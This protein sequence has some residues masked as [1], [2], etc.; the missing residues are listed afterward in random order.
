MTGCTLSSPPKEI[1]IRV[2]H[3]PTDLYYKYRDVYPIGCD[4]QVDVNSDD[5]DE[6]N[7]K[8]GHA[9]ILFN[10]NTAALD[11]SDDGDE[12]DLV[13]FA[14]PHH[15]QIL[16][17]HTKINNDFQLQIG[18]VGN[19][20]GVMGNSWKMEETLSSLYWWRIGEVFTANQTDQILFQLQ[21]DMPNSPIMNV[22]DPYGFGKEIARLGRLALI[23]DEF[24][25]VNSS[26]IIR[27]YMKIS[28]E[29][30][31][32]IENEDGV[33]NSDPLKYEGTYG[34]VC[35]TNGL[36]TPGEPWAPGGA[37]D[38]GN[39]IYNDHHYHYGYWIYGIAAVIKEDP[40]WYLNNTQLQNLVLSLCRD[41]ANP[42]K[43][44]PYFTQF[45]Y[46]D[47]YV[48]HSWA[49]G[50]QVI[51]DGTNQES[52]SEAINAYYGLSLLGKALN[53]TH[54]RDVGRLLASMEIRSAQT[55]WQIIPSTNTIYPPSFAALGIASQQFADKATYAVFFECGND[56]TV[57]N[58]GINI[59]PITPVTGLLLN[60]QWVDETY[61]LYAAA[62]F[63][64]LNQWEGF[65]IADYAVID[66]N[67]AWNQA[68]NYPPPY[69]NGFSL[70][71]L[72]HFIAT[73]SSSSVPLNFSFYYF[74][75]FLFVVINL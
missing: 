66:Q 30:A 69:D 43:E 56:V 7:Q 20:N 63:T 39:G 9:S 71:A 75:L 6:T 5:D 55:Y 74:F 15:R 19:V 48:G 54:M 12:D 50:L 4:V 10:W 8:D 18:L 65:R 68:I 38:Y 16:S 53:N 24:G 46:K 33:V 52:I 58:Y 60:Y 26:V 22:T 1:A 73:R 23:A 62:D 40:D 44:D 37:A 2:A 28:L 21:V 36:D 27:N 42:S 41:F 57:C 64:G 67:D 72:E 32:G 35:S 61:S 45:R 3:N 34:G 59:I 14:L 47:W 17:S 11:G 13:I 49:S 29:S 31:L 25:Q 51:A 70:T